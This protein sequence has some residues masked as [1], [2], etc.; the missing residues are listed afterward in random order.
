M[1]AFKPIAFQSSS[2]CAPFLTDLH[3]NFKF[4]APLIKWLNENFFFVNCFAFLMARYRVWF[5]AYDRVTWNPIKQV[6]N[7]P[8]AVARQPIHYELEMRSRQGVHQAVFGRIYYSGLLLASFASKP[9]RTPQLKC[10][11]SML[12]IYYFFSSPNSVMTWIFFVYNTHDAD[13]EI[14]VFF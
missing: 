2:F 7:Y 9:K 6:F 13:L 10:A 3:F 12:H 5:S 14:I 11:D 4:F 1:T 8:T